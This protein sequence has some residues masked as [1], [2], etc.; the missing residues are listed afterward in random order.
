LMKCLGGGE[1]RSFVILIDKTYS[2]I[3]GG[4]EA[5]CKARKF[6]RGLPI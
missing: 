4:P 1:G 6:A 3:L 5:G 2:S